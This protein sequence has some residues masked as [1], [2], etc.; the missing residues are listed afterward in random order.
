MALEI[1]TSIQIN[2]TP[3]KVWKKLISFEDYPNWN[4]FIKELKGDVKVGNKINVNAGGMNFTP[5]VLAFTENKEL[6][7]IGKLLFTGVFDG[8]HKFELIDNKDGT[9]TFNH[10]EIFKGFLVGMFK[11]K[12]MRDTKSGFESMNQELK[13]LVEK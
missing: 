3:D 12:L 4:P 10:S 8:E 11:N 13:N 5:E 2:A 6:R 9:T 1:K 7:W